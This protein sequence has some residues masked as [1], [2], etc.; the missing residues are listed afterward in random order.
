VALADAT[1]GIG[2]E[3]LSKAILE[4]FEGE[5]H[6]VGVASSINVEDIGILRD[7]SLGSEF[8]AALLDQFFH[9]IL[10]NEYS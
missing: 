10:R 5:F 1:D 9:A 3:K 7:I 6:L 4:G 2:L 8:T